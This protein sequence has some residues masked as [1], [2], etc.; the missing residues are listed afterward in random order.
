MTDVDTDFK[1][2]VAETIDA[3]QVVVDLERERSQKLQELELNRGSN[4]GATGGQLFYEAA[5][6][7]STV[8]QQLGR[9]LIG[10]G[11]GIAA[12]NVNTALQHQKI[13]EAY[14]WTGG[15]R[16]ASSRKRKSSSA[17]IGRAFGSA[18]SFFKRF[19][20]QPDGRFNERL[21]PSA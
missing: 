19:N 2:W 15:S 12:S 7:G 20:N 3:C 1:V 13:D 10:L 5:N 14:P 18:R 21:R 6:G 4:A 16:S 8:G 9:G 17:T 11:V